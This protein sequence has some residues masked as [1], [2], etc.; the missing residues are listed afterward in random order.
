MEILRHLSIISDLVV[1]VACFDYDLK[2]K[3]LKDEAI[4]CYQ[5]VFYS[6]SSRG[7]LERELRIVRIDEYADFVVDVEKFFLD[8]M[9]FRPAIEGTFSFLFACPELKRREY[10]LHVLKVCCLCVDHVNPK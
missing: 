3:L 8:D 6:L 1:G 5:H 10:T 4:D 9:C 7:S 2:F